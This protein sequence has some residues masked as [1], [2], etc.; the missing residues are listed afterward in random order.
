M[1][2][3]VLGA[4]AG[5]GFPQ[6]NCNCTRCTGL[7]DGT[8]AARPRTPASLAISAD[9]EHWL[10]LGATPDVRVQIE[11]TP[12]LW[13]HHGGSPI[14]AVALPNGDID[15]WVGLLSL[16]EWSPLALFATPVVHSDVAD[17]NGVFRALDQFA[18]HSRWID[19]IPSQPAAT[20]V[21]RGL[22]IEAVPSPG[23]PPLHQR[24]RRAP[25]PLD[26][27]GLIVR[28]V[29]AGTS[30][31]WFPSVGGPSQAIEQALGSVD[32]VFFDG[33]YFR[34]D[35]LSANG[36]DSVRD[37]GHWSV[38][39]GSAAFLETLPA[40]A[41][42]LVHLHSTNPLLVEDG[43]EISWLRQRGIDIAYDGLRLDL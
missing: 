28:D 42:W 29:V 27:V 3:M 5:G 31:A 21:L 10:L 39:D 30:I 32:V 9:G 26:N 41:R 8:L 16:R 14:A 35:E 6:W 2:A 24:D 22:T 33:T 23:Q 37:T 38:C 11:R 15:S 1:R 34:D 12:E 13:P 36:V 17:D 43:A 25:D 40:K 7:R 18:G 20:A 4:G 19:L